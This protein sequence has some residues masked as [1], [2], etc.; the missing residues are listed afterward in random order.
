MTK[1]LPD[2]SLLWEWFSFN[3]LTGQLY[4]RKTSSN[5]TPTGSLAGSNGARYRYVRLLGHRY[6]AHRIIYKWVTSS[7]PG[8]LIEH[9]D[10]DG[11]NNRFSN[12]LNSTQRANMNTRWNGTKG[13]SLTRSSGR[14]TVRIMFQ[15]QQIYCG[16]YD[17]TTEAHA[18][19]LQAISTYDISP[20]HSH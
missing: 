5:K 4:W 1:A 10:D 13:Y 3:P 11:F 16:T 15:G 7:E 14:Y 17:T 8:P 20:S 19:Y 9:R 2:V 12:L 18:A 6:L